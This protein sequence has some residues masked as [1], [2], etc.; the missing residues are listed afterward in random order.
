MK[1]ITIAKYFNL[2]IESEVKLPKKTWDRFIDLSDPKIKK[3]IKDWKNYNLEISSYTGGFTCPYPEAPEK[4]GHKEYWV[5]EQGL[6]K[7]FTINIE[8]NLCTDERRKYGRKA[9]S[10]VTSFEIPMDLWFTVR[11]IDIQNEQIIEKKKRKC[12][13]YEKTH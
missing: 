4:R 8:R 5:E 9:K 10:V 1:P 7:H 11:R 2:K 3:H 13:Y 12:N 6:H